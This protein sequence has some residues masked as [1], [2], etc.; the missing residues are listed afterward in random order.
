ME[1][2]KK[3]KKFSEIS[4]AFLNALLSFKHL[5]KKVTLIADL[6]P[7]IPAPKEMVTEISKKKCSRR[8]LE[9]QQG[10]W[11]ETLYQSE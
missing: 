11:F 6:F 2:S 7:E 5:L 4:F 10:K 8:P 1:L 9:R 3:Q